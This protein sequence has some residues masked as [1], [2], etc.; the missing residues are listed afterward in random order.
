M[1]HIAAVA[2]F[3]LG[4]HGFASAQSGAVTVCLLGTGGPELTSAR[5]G[6]STLVIANGQNLLFDAGRNVL[7]EIYES[8]ITPQS[9]TEIFLTHLHSDHIEGLPSLWMT[10]WFLLGRQ[11]HLRVWGPPG[12]RS[13]VE[14]MRLMYTHDVERRAT[15]V[16]KKEYLDIEVHEVQPGAV[17]SQGAVKVTAFAVE[18]HDG[19]PAFG[20]RID[21]GGRAVLLTGDTTLTDNLAN[22][23]RHVDVLISN[24]AA[25]TQELERS[26]G[27][28]PI[29]DKLMRPEQA[30]SLFSAAMPR[31]AVYSHI[32]KKGLPGKDGDEVILGRTRAAGYTGPLRM[33]VDRMR[34]V[35]G[36]Q[37]RVLPPPPGPDRDFDHP[38]ASF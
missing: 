32:V 24:V 12:T 14:G 16:F 2:V 33:G 6:E 30:A 5:A 34:I 8:G 13:M 26:G 22:M 38:G 1:R 15:S 11:S 17:Y 19:D 10:P 31:L 21:A 4:L 27:I 28:T 9:V 18:H 35:V 20:Y 23:A 29:L 25:G 7:Q 3:L 37:I 36:D